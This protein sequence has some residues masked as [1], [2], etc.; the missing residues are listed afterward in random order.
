MPPLTPALGVTC[1]IGFARLQRTY[2]VRSAAFAAALSRKRRVYPSPSIYLTVQASTCTL[3]R[4]ASLKGCTHPCRS[5]LTMREQS[6]LARVRRPNNS[7]K[8][9]A[10]T[11]AA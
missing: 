10:L 3:T 6:R 9:D 11:R 4:T 7:F 1:S 5:W 8:A 2:T